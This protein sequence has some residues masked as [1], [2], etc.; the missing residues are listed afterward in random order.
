MTIKE[1][2]EKNFIQQYELAKVL[3]ITQP[4]L[5]MVENGKAKISLKMKKKFLALYGFIPEEAK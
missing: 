4:L 3:E 5:S 2:R 1:F